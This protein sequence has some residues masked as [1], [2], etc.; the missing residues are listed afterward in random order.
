[1]FTNRVHLNPNP[2]TTQKGRLSPLFSKAGRVA[3][4]SAESK[5]APCGLPHQP[6]ESWGNVLSLKAWLQNNE[7]LSQFSG[8]DLPTAHSG[9]YVLAVLAIGRV[10]EG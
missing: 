5:E 8:A 4:H 2:A 9:I 3:T 10:L 7:D 6:S 1:M